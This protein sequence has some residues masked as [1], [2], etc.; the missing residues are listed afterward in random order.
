MPLWF[1]TGVSLV[2][3]WCVTDVSVVCQ[4]MVRSARSVSSKRKRFDPQ[5]DGGTLRNV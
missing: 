1:V 3:H 5:Q 4:L 2:C